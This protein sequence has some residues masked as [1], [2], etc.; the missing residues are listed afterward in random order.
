MQR[1]VD[2]VKF[3][4]VSCRENEAKFLMR[5][6]EGKLRI[7]LAE[8]T[9]LVALAHA[10]VLFR[11]KN[12]SRESLEE[13][14]TQAS[15]CIKTAF[16]ELPNYERI[17]PPLILHGYDTLEQHCK[18]TPGIPVK[19]MLAHPTKSLSEVLTRFEGITF[20]C[21]YKYDGERAQLHRLED[22]SMRIY[23]RNS[24]DMT[25]KYP[26]I[27][28]KIPSFTSEHTTSF[29]LDC[30]AVAWDKEERKIMPF[31]V[32]STRKRKD[33]KEEDIKVQVV[34]FAFDLLY[35]NGQ[36]N[37]LNS[38]TFSLYCASPLPR[39]GL[40]CSMPLRRSRA[41]SPS[42]RVWSSA[43]SRKSKHSWTKVSPTIAR[44]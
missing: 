14:L 7:G 41:S 44:A 9:V 22:G 19:P 43:K 11:H 29:V 26:D 6:L 32:L 5:S 8:K 10:S 31:Q 42:L 13:K 16:S 35:L 3:L 12:L 25:Q 1:K 40:R 15:E 4:L 18:L 38:L 36:V 27:M 21:E 30:E 33:V 20:T 34:V 17:A 2:K 39:G 23:S 24:E 28:G 37:S